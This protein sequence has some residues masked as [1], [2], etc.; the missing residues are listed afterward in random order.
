MIDISKELRRTAITISRKNGGTVFTI[1]ECIRDRT[2]PY[3]GDFH[4]AESTRWR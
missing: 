1:K 2:L 3:G 4:S